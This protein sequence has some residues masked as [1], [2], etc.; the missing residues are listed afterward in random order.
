MSLWTNV[1]DSIR[2]FSI[3]C[4]CV[5]SVIVSTGSSCTLL[6]LIVSSDFSSSWLFRAFQQ[7]NEHR[8]MLVLVSFEVQMSWY[9]QICIKICICLMRSCNRPTNYSQNFCCHFGLIASILTSQLN[10][11]KW[12][13]P[14]NPV[15]SFA[16]FRLLNKSVLMSR[17]CAVY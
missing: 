4:D 14:A 16:L 9:L 13:L 1:D 10:V 2:Q 8:R 11:A 7:L 6:H 3:S 15:Q 5:H 17:I 12:M